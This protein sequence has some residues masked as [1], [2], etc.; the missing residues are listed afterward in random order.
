MKAPWNRA[1][2]R[3]RR[4]ALRLSVPAIHE[5]LHRRVPRGQAVPS[6][7]RLYVELDSPKAPGP[8]P[9]RRW[10]LAALAEILSCKPK[11]LYNP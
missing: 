11:E 5:E 3:A 8:H 10:M 9:R 7:T 6:L 2:F 4:K 1:Y